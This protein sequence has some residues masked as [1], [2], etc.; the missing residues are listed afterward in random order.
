MHEGAPVGA[1]L[2]T[3]RLSVTGGS[4]LLAVRG[5]LVAASVAFAIG[6]A[7]IALAGRSPIDAYA[8]LW[9]G[10]FGSGAAIG[11]TL[12]TA[13]PLIFTGL[14]VALSFRA[15]LFN[16][17]GEGQFYLGAVAAA[18]LGAALPFG[19]FGGILLVIIAAA[20]AGGAWAGFAGFLKARLGASEIVTTLML[21][22]IAVSFTLWATLKPLSAGTGQSSSTPIRLDMRLPQIADELGRA[23]VGLFLA[24]LAAVVIYVLLWRTSWGYELRATGLSPQAAEYAGMPVARNIVLAM[25]L[26]GAIAGVGGAIEV[27][28]LYG[29]LIAPF[30]VG[31]GFYGIAVALIGRLHPVGCVIGAILLGALSS[32]GQT[33]Q[34]VADVPQNLA[35]VLTGLILLLVTASRVP[36]VLR[37]MIARRGGRGAAPSVAPC[38]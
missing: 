16:V 20:L 4:V 18:W 9:D 25:A 12:L 27:L 33:M 23:H 31:I 17:G 26:S 34:F 29:K 11:R 7:I 1:P 24:L 38:A 10:A 32:G 30:V 3:S 28:G 36:P 8:A 14:A 37:R 22:I 19:G 35:D 5:P 21:N 13:T 15:G 2:R 6:A